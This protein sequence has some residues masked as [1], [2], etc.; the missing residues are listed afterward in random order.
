[1]EIG[2][3]LKVLIF[4]IF[5][6]CT[7]ALSCSDSGSNDE[8]LGSNQSEDVV[9]GRGVSSGKTLLDSFLRET[10]TQKPCRLSS[11]EDGIDLVSDKVIDGDFDDWIGIESTILDEENDSDGKFDLKSFSTGRFNSDLVFSVLG[12]NSVFTDQ[13]VK[14]D[15]IGG[16]YAD[17]GEVRLE[18]LK[19][20][21]MTKSGIEIIDNRGIYTFPDHLM[22]VVWSDQGLEGRIDVNYGLNEV[23]IYP[24]WGIFISIVEGDVVV[25]SSH[26]MFFKGAVDGGFRQF[27]LNNCLDDEFSYLPVSFQ[28]I[29]SIDKPVALS[30]KGAQTA[31]GMVRYVE[32]GISE[33]FEKSSYGVS[34][35]PVVISSDPVNSDYIDD[36]VEGLGTINFW[37]RGD[38]F[39]LAGYDRNIHDS[40]LKSLTVVDTADA[41]AGIV[42][43][44]W[45]YNDI[46]LF[47]LAKGFVVSRYVIANMDRYQFMLLL[48]NN[49]NS[50]YFK[51]GSVLGTFLHDK[52]LLLL[53]N[54]ESNFEQFWLKIIENFRTE[55][56]NDLVELTVDDSSISAFIDAYFMDEDYDGIPRF[57]EVKIGTDPSVSDTDGDGWTDLSES[58]MIDSMQAD[59]SNESV[60]PSAII[61]DGSFGDVYDL[62]PGGVK[63]SDEG[64]PPE[65]SK[66]SDFKS[67][68]ALV[69]S[70]GLYVGIES[71]GGIEDDEIVRFEFNIDIVSSKKRYKSVLRTEG[72]IV[73]LF[74]GDTG[75]LKSR[76]KLPFT[77][78][79]PAFEIY[80]P[81]TEFEE[82]EIKVE[83]LKIQVRSFLDNISNVYCDETPIFEPSGG[84]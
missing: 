7:T 71:F 35:I 27:S 10:N 59:P 51:L 16:F 21:L 13:K 47:Q 12:H 41:L 66:V 56:P 26:T 28:E 29:R 34:S 63:V 24:I 82:A 53:I 75:G 55:L 49:Q 65:C 50:M 4:G 37:G 73:E 83:N 31:F 33:I 74:R 54:R 6:L 25:D 60:Y 23:F 48:S 32:S 40:N 1:M 46:N 19:S 58:T 80:I 70:N 64:V 9:P 52:D 62:V 36:M 20:I 38:K 61:A 8:P 78:Q 77:F 69:S 43:K 81:V 84:R 18:N 57:Y 44:N 30:D 68:I 11:S 39:Q 14:L 67:Y 17:T 42:L 15:V 79:G 22:D 5:L 45:L 72:D 2:D 76:E 3:T